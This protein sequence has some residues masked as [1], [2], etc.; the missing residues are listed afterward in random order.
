MAQCSSGNVHSGTVSAEPISEDQFAFLRPE[1]S[2]DREG[3]VEA[4]VASLVFCV[5]LQE[6]FLEGGGAFRGQSSLL[7]VEL[8][9]ENNRMTPFVHFHVPRMWEEP[10]PISL[11]VGDMWMYLVKKI[12]IT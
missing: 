12:K 8:D 2:P 4:A 10:L 11:W 6:D 7:A 1:R 9:V 5:W 3:Q